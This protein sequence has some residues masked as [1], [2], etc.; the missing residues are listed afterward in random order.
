MKIVTLANYKVTIIAPYKEIVRERDG[1][2]PCVSNYKFTIFDI[3]CTIIRSQLELRFLT[4]FYVTYSASVIKCDNL[5][6]CQ[7]D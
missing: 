5:T 3:D 1:L 6:N 2:L 4:L 7:R